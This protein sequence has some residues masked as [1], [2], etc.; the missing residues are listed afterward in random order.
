VYATLPEDA[1]HGVFINIHTAKDINS[2][3]IKYKLKN[4]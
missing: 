4:I 3:Y 1:A 2:V